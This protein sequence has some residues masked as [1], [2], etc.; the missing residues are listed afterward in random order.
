M[1]EDS[2]EMESLVASQYELVR[3]ILEPLSDSDLDSC[4][5]VNKIGPMQSKQKEIPFI[6]K[7]LK[8]S[9]GKGH[10]NK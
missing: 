8:C 10:P 2:C 9:A 1:A 5:K 3:R 6:E 4:E 7:K